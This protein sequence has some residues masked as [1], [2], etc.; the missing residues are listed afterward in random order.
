MVIQFEFRKEQKE[1]IRAFGTFA[2]EKNECILESYEV[3]APEI[4]DWEDCV[5]MPE[6]PGFT[7]FGQLDIRLDPTCTGWTEGKLSA[8]SQ[9]KCWIKFQ[10]KSL[11]IDHIPDSGKSLIWCYWL[12]VNRY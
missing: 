9:I 2:S 6:M 7:L 12:F 11:N 3:E 1:N 10:D 5:P 8:Q 4:S